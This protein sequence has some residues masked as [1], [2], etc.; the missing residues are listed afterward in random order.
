ME[1]DL[2]DERDSKVA[3]AALLLALKMKKQSWVSFFNSL[4]RKNYKHLF[5]QDATLTFYSRYEEEQLIALSYK[6]NDVISA[7]AKS[8]LKTIRTKYSHRIFFEVAKIPPLP[9]SKSIA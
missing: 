8:N 1:Y 6:L 4:R 2:I 5:F 7:P 3:A 9:K